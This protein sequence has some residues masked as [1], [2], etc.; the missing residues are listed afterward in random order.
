[1]FDDGH[2][3]P[4]RVLATRTHGATLGS[5]FGVVQAGLV[6]RIAEHR[7]TQAHRNAR[8]VHHVE[9][10]AQAVAW[11]AYQVAD[12]TRAVIGHGG[13]NREFALAKIQQRVRHAAIAELVIQA[14]QRHVVAL[15][16]EFAVFV[17][18]LLRHDEQR[19]AFGAWNQ[20]AV[21]IGNFGQHQMDDVFGQLML[22]VGYPHFVAA[23][24][25]AR[26]QR[27]KFRLHAI[28]HGP[29]HDVRQT[30]P[31]LRLT[32]AHRARKPA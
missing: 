4:C 18:Q 16:R 7:R 5:R 12:G 14:R 26:T 8:L 32:Q 25:V 31:G 15:A 21:C 23:Q 6:T 24:P 27:I 3:R 29:R 28:G 11:L 30:R 17:H 13:A 10:A 19:D 9:H 2:L 22:T 1:M 20:L